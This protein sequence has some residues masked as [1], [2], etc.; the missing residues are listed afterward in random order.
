VKVRATQ[1]EEQPDRPL[2]A[3]VTLIDPEASEFML[4]EEAVLQA[5]AAEA[6]AKNGDTP[7]IASSGAGGSSASA[8]ASVVTDAVLRH[9]VGCKPGTR[10]DT[11]SSL[12]MHIPGL[13]QLLAEE[14]VLG[15]D[16]ISLLWS[17]GSGSNDD[18]LRKGVF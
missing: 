7:G 13:L 8:S 14:G 4:G 18:D 9:A 3:L 17:V 16:D 6:E 15:S 10:L 2:R 11:H 5:A 12:A 1:E